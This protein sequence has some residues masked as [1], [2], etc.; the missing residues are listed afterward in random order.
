MTARVLDGTFWVLRSAPHGAARGAWANIPPRCNR[1]EPICSSPHLHR[2]CNS[3]ERFSAR[4]SIIVANGGRRS[5]A[6]AASNLSVQARRELISGTPDS[7]IRPKPRRSFDL[8]R[9]LEEIDGAEVYLVSE[10]GYLIDEPQ[11]IEVRLRPAS[12]TSIP[13][14]RPRSTRTIAAKLSRLHR[15]ADD[16]LSAGLT[17]IDA[18]ASNDGRHSRLSSGSLTLLFFQVTRARCMLDKSREIDRAMPAPDWV[19]LPA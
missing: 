11:V 4:S 18:S 13:G 7:D 10:I 2:A 3:D 16:L 19:K 1:T 17:A 5:I 8:V 6:P 12:D 9:Q 15:M 14:L